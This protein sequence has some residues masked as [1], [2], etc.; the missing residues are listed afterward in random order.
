M[1]SCLH[2]HAESCKNWVKWGLIYHKSWMCKKLFDIFDD[3]F[4]ELFVCYWYVIAK[5]FPLHE[6]PLKDLFF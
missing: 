2:P 5:S 4:D 3:L 1:L 6:I